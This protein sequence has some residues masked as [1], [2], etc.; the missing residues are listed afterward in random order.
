MPQSVQSVP[1]SHAWKDAPVPP[2]SQPPSAAQLQVSL[3]PGVEGGKGEGEEA[4]PKKS[5]RLGAPVEKNTMAS[6]R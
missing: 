6:I 5:S 1:K 2:S 4:L 3:H